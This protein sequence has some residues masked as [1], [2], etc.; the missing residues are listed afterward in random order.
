MSA[1]PDEPAVETGARAELASRL[2]GEVWP[3]DRRRPGFNRVVDGPDQTPAAVVAAAGPAD[4]A[5]AV[6][7]A[8][9]HDLPVGVQATGHGPAL[10]P[11][12]ALLID[13]AALDGV[14]IDPVARTA[15]VQ[16]GVPWGAVVHEAAAHG[17]APLNGASPSVG[18]VG[19][20]LG[21]GHGPLGRSYGYSADHVRELDVVTADGEVRVA[22][23]DAHADLFWGLRGGKGNFGVVT[24]MLV[25]LFEVPSI[26][27]GGLFLPGEAAPELLRRWRDWTRTLADATHTAISLTRFPAD[28]GLPEPVRGRF[29]VHLRVAHNGPAAEGE[30]LLAPMRAGAEPVYDTV[31][32]MPYSEVADVHMDPTAPGVYL[33]R[34]RRL[35]DLDDGTIEAILDLTG[36]DGSAPLASVELRLLGG[37]LARPPAEPNAVSH[38]EARYTLFTGIPVAEGEAESVRVAQQ[39]L[40]DAVE[41]WTLG[42]PF[43]SFLSALEADVASV[44]AAYDAPTWEGLVALKRRHDPKNLF[45]LTHNVPP[46]AG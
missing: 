12:G 19:Y 8:A 35:A 13:T 2:R 1:V 29:L 39:R 7:F 14:R 40:L 44:R 38:R 33:E 31:R 28:P 25:D 20:T 17:L 24:S 15:Q 10:S 5:E 22:R 11:R 27:G 30:R 26:Y 21:G 16:A 46:I 34:S 42:G 9:R 18:V 23:P 6:R 4:V 41:P 36:P 32:A 3:G 43:V 37:A 45:R